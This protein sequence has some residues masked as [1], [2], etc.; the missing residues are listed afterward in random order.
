MLRSWGPSWAFCLISLPFPTFEVW[1]RTGLCMA[2]LLPPS[3]MGPPPPPSTTRPYGHFALV[4]RVQEEGHAVRAQVAILA[5][6]VV[7]HLQQ[8][9]LLGRVALVGG[10]QH[11]GVDSD[12]GVLGN[13]PVP[14]GGMVLISPQEARPGPEPSIHLGCHGL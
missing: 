9:L 14:T 2:H 4:Q 12:L 11:G 13:D 3:A 5:G 6:E 10:G 1:P 8:M 7:C